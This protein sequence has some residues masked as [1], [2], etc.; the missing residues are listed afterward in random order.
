MEFVYL[1]LGIQPRFIIYIISSSWLNWKQEIIIHIYFKQNSSKANNTDYNVNKQ[2]WNIQRF[3][4]VILCLSNLNFIFFCFL[5]LCT[6]L[7]FTVLKSSYWLQY[8]STNRTWKHFSFILIY[9]PHILGNHSVLRS[10][11][12]EP[13]F[14]T[15]IIL[16]FRITFSG[17]GSIRER[18]ISS[19]SPIL[20]PG[21]LPVLVLVLLRP[22]VLK[23]RTGAVFFPRSTIV[24]LTEAGILIG[25]VTFTLRTIR[26]K[27]TWTASSIRSNLSIKQWNLYRDTTPG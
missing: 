9:N 14:T 17:S 1:V 10:L 13:Q 27:E 19:A 24:P 22:V 26:E 8:I 20:P 18:I 6:Q 4:R 7:A 25:S 5:I 12:T 11:C 2:Q 21:P 23:G 15:T 3:Y 16:T